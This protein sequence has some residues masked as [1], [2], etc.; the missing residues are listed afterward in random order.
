MERLGDYTAKVN[1]NLKVLVF[2][3]LGGHKGTVRST[4]FGLIVAL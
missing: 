4:L 2:F 1:L 3:Q